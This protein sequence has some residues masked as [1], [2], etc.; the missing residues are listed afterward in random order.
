MDVLMCVVN[1]HIEAYKHGNII[2]RNRNTSFSVSLLSLHL[3]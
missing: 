1:T 3:Y 2:I